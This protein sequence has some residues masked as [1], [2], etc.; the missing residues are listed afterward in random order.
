MSPT[1]VKV[2]KLKI[3]NLNLKKKIIS[4]SKVITKHKHKTFRENLIAEITKTLMIRRLPI[5]FEYCFVGWRHVT[6]FGPERG[7]S[8]TIMVFDPTSLVFI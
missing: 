2:D 5:P 6:S 1:A 4:I 8:I 3:A 7:V